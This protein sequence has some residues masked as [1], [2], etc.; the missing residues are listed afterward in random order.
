[1]A[2]L[3][4]GRSGYIGGKTCVELLKKGYEVVIVDNFGNS[5]PESA[6]C[7]QKVTG[8]PV[9]FYESSLLDRE[10]LCRIFDRGNIEGV[11]YFAGLKDA[12]TSLTKPLKYYHN[13]ITSIL[14]LCDVMC[15]YGVKDIVFSSL[16][17]VHGNP[18]FVPATEE[19]LQEKVTDP[20]G[21]IRSMLEQI[22]I[23][24]HASDPEW[25]VV[26]LRYFYDVIDGIGMRD[27]THA[28]NL[29]FGHVKAIEKLK[30]KEGV[31][32]YNL[33]TGN[34]CSVKAG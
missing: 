15:K 29:A 24:I 23:D 14:A 6:K 3:V 19:W 26:L 2:I 21:R 10:S 8:K 7:I 27:C 32:V 28:V 17:D 30:D 25:N 11:I 9:A 20:C 4:T 16:A 13:N 12:G 18:T 1:M 31:K 33:G 22:F 5:S 34:D